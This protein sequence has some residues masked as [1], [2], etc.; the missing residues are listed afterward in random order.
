MS[1]TGA[2]LDAE[3]IYVETEFAESGSGGR[4]CK[5]GTYD[6]DVKIALV[7]GVYKVLVSFVVGPFLSDGTFGNLRVDGVLGLVAGFDVGEFLHDGG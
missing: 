3:V 5:A 1:A 6:D 2:V 7:G 4:A